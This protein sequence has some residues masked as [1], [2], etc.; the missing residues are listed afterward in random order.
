MRHARLLGSLLAAVALAGAASAAEDYPHGQLPNGV[1]PLHYELVLSIDPR[2][3]EFAGYTTIRLKITKPTQ[4]I[5]L[6]GL[7]LRIGSAMLRAGGKSMDVKYTE[8]DAVGGVARLDLPETA[9]AGDAT[10]RI[11]YRANF[12]QGAEG[13]GRVVVGKDSYVFSQMEPIDA[14]RVFPSFDEPLFKTPFALTV[15]APAGDSVI[16]NAELAASMPLQ[17]GT[18]RHRFRD[19]LPLP[20]YLIALAVGPLDIVDGGMIPASKI[21]STPVPLRGVATRGQGARLR[22]AL[23]N[24]PK[25]VAELEAYFGIPY[26]YPKLDLIAS[27]DMTGAMENA[28][29]IIF[30]D[31]L[32]LL[33]DNAPPAQQ[34]DFF[35][36]A[37]HEIAHHWF[38]DFVTPR[39][40]DDLWLNESFAEWMNLK[41]A[42]RLR[43]DLSPSTSVVQEAESAMDTDSLSVGRPIHEAIGDN[44]RIASAF[45]SITYQ[46]G[47]GVLSMFESYMGAATFQRGVQMHL[48]RHPNGGATSN[49]FFA[50][51]AAAAGKPEIVAAFRSFVTQAGVPLVAVTK[52]SAERL[53]VSQTRYT[54]L[55]STIQRGQAW[56]IPLCVTL[57]GERGNAKQCMLLQGAQASMQIPRSIGALQAVMPNADGAGYYR[58]V[59]PAADTAALLQRGASLPDRE[60]LALADSM[61]GSF[62]A[63]QATLAQLLD[64]ARI[65]AQHS[66]R[67]VATDLGWELRAIHDRLLDPE[68]RPEMRRLIAAIYAPR[69]QASGDAVDT[70]GMAAATADR[71]LLRRA[72]VRLVAL[73]ARDAVVRARLSAAAIL[74]QN[75]PTA[76]DIGLRDS[77]WAVAADD[78]QLGFFDALVHRLGSSDPLEREHAAIALGSVK[79]SALAARALQIAGDPKVG[80]NEA[81]TILG[82]QLEAA[83]TRPAAWQW[84]LVNFDNFV[85]RLPGFVKPY[86]FTFAGSAC[87]MVTRGELAKIGADKVK[88][89]GGGQLELDRSLESIDLCIAQ[90][91]AHAAEFRELH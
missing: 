89:F 7:G 42:N 13:L 43:P 36:V 54:P 63:G 72:L 75:T 37:S 5:W 1:T 65:L 25:I 58:F 47:A 34:R 87:D 70:A 17:N 49:D 77:A 62:R 55:G 8:V 86:V 68:Q 59:L 33:S 76:L 69:L 14:R 84:F 91:A 83:E 57:Y 73:G 16:G 56:Q 64:A 66:N 30:G 32:L 67:Q 22:F 44:A 31:S 46:K 10:L 85:A 38:G 4:R 71:Q 23:Q 61:R 80:I 9:A 53:T 12:R 41:I 28:G 39:W 27:P 24:T 29:A 20:T 74:A 45:D 78:Q 90:K 3:S 82:R 81:L 40:W 26:P 48:R 35:E 79:D 52:T 88:Q 19:T 21:R 11:A 18:V 50:A 60:A 51:I 2:S 6:H 15:I